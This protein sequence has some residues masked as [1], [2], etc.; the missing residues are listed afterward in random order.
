M[1][2]AA[3]TQVSHNSISNLNRK[4]TVKALA[5]TSLCSKRTFS[6]QKR[7]SIYLEARRNSLHQSQRPKVTSLSCSRPP[8]QHLP[9]CTMICRGTGMWKEWCVV[10]MTTKSLVLGQNVHVFTRLPKH[11]PLV[12][13]PR[14]WLVAVGQQTGWPLLIS[15]FQ[16]RSQNPPAT[17]SPGVQ[18]T[19]HWSSSS[20]NIRT[21]K[22]E[23]TFPCGQM[24]IGMTALHFVPLDWQV[25]CMWSLAG[26]VCL[27]THFCV[28]QSGFTVKIESSRQT[29][30][31]W[32]YVALR[33]V[34][35]SC[36]F[37]NNTC[38]LTGGSSFSSITLHVGSWGT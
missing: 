7:Q 19:P 11:C 25:V 22:R 17:V 8:S 12:P 15:G 27:A 26:P 29:K 24:P 33:S 4:Q 5:L 14:R 32:G 31:L 23:M 10:G 36:Y 9:S 38:G 30:S 21:W 28:F 1:Q 34:Q 35:H 16:L 18:S 2:L 13:H 37:L 6:W 3:L 20:A